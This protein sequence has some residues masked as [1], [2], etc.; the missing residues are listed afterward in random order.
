MKEKKQTLTQK[1]S[2]FNKQCKDKKVT[3]GK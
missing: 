2:K 1:N 3:E